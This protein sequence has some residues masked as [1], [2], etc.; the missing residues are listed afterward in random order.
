MSVGLRL[1]VLVVPILSIIIVNLCISPKMTVATSQHDNLAYVNVNPRFGTSSSRPSSPSPLRPEIAGNGRA[2]HHVPRVTAKRIDTRIPFQLVPSVTITSRSMKVLNRDVDVEVKQDET[3]GSTDELDVVGTERCFDDG[4]EDG[5]RNAVTHSQLVPSQTITNQN[6]HKRYSSRSRPT[7]GLKM[8]NDDVKD[9][10]DGNSDGGGKN[11]H[12]SNSGRG[13][14]SKPSR[15]TQFDYGRAKI[16]FKGNIPNVHWRAI[17]MND[18]RNHPLYHALPPPN[19]ISLTKLEDVRNFRQDSWQWGALHVGR[20]TTSYVSMALGF[21]E[22]K[23]G[24]RLGIPMSLQRSSDGAFGRL[25]E[26]GSALRTLEEM[27][28]VL[29]E[30][31]D[32]EDEED[33]MQRMVEQRGRRKTHNGDG[34]T[35]I[36]KTTKNFPFAAKMQV[37]PTP[38]AVTANSTTQERGTNSTN[39]TRHMSV[40]MKWGNAQEATAILT[41]LNYFA[42]K[43]P[44]VTIQEVGMCG[45]GLPL[46]TSTTDSQ[47]GDLLLGASPDALIR[48]GNGSLEVLEVKNHCPFFPSTW[49]VK[50]RNRKGRQTYD[51]SPRNASEAA[52]FIQDLPL[53][54]AIP[55]GYIP[56]LMMEMMCMGDQ[57]QSAIMLRQTGTNGA[58]IS[59]LRRDDDWIEEMLYWLNQFRDR[60]VCKA[61]K[62]SSN[63]FW[64]DDIDDDEFLAEDQEKEPRG[65]SD[66]QIIRYRAFVHR[67]K[68]ISKSA[69]LVDYVRHQN[70]QRVNGLQDRLFLD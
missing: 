40:R 66:P 26:G 15:P 70:I 28:E 50:S 4:G 62:P 56:Q 13:R 60:Y 44:N 48:H 31:G 46:N 23:T 19:T 11:I 6:F 1:S 69:E 61:R 53:Y 35:W 22:P 10:R 24:R 68:E 27:V 12:S 54:A 20:C 45:A 18:L 51:N 57:C 39:A 65:D 9:N 16:K 47:Y 43:D 3:S 25:A 30:N 41:A 17:T 8:K 42:A 37:S 14:R 55:P 34:V 2:H 58:V 63:F 5:I 64:Y 29:C 49:T 52:F 38:T 36:R 67:T 59:R 32:G 21:L 7:T 33:G